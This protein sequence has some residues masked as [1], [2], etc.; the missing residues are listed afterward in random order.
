MFPFP[1]GNMCLKAR[2][3]K[4]NFFASNNLHKE[5]KPTMLGFQ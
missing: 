1:Q 2:L 4:Q 5:S 3:G